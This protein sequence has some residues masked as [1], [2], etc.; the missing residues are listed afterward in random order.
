ML[1][2]NIAFYFKNKSEV[3]GLYNTNHVTIS[4]VCTTRCDISQLVD[5]REVISRFNPEIVVHCAALTDIDRCESDRELARKI[6]IQ[7]TRH[8]VESIKDSTMMIYISTDA[9]YDGIRGN[10]S[11]E[12]NINPQNYY[13]VSK[14][15]GELEALKHTNTLVLRTNIFGWNIQ[16]KK[17]L[18][19]W[20]LG[21]LEVGRK[22]SCFKDARFSS[23]YTFELAKV[24]DILMRSNLRGVYNCCSSD[25]C[26]KYEFAL[27]L[28]SRFGLDK[29]LITPIS[30]DDFS[31]KARRGK[32]LAL[33]VS[34]LKKE[35]DYELPT[36]GQ[37]LDSF[38][39][40]FLRGFPKSNYGKAYLYEFNE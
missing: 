13:G 16:A 28:A 3:L 1:G 23:I 37:S 17:S 35:L 19:E 26:S 9:V 31:F 25:S 22:I 40:D 30:I 7:S 29:T 2:N 34:K 32:N 27:M 21:E 10:F 38:Y 14:Y 33:N 18:G 11:E 20:I 12:D 24:L 15:E 36:I 6:N 8:I 39:A 4:G 5:I